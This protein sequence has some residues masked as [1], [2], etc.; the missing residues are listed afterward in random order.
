MVLSVMPLIAL[1]LSSVAD[2]LLLQCKN[3]D[4][5]LVEL[6]SVVQ[7]LHACGHL[8]SEQSHQP[9]VF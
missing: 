3:F 9:I 6:F 7:Q 8:F 2:Q 5:C 4:F 1:S